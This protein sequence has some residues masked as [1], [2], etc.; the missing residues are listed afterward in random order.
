M[1]GQGLMQK[2]KEPKPPASAAGFSWPSPRATDAATRTK[3]H[4]AVTELMRG[5]GLNYLQLAREIWGQHKDGSS[6]NPGTPR[7]WVKGVGFP[8]KTT[9]AYVAR[10]FDVPMSALLNPQGKFVPMPLVR[11]GKA[12]GH[13]PMR[14]VQ[15]PFEGKKRKAYTKHARAPLP[16]RLALPADAPALQVKL[17][18]YAG[19]PHFMSISISGTVQVEVAMALL[20]M[21]HPEPPAPDDV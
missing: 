21:L 7:E 6:R 20:A 2:L 10:F 18:T 5:R 19:D 14:P 12:N 17:E 9:A 13:D 1:A 8:S 15:I 16:A 11:G 4:A 3:F